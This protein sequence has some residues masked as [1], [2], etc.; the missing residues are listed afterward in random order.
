MERWSHWGPNARSIEVCLANSTGHPLPFQMRGTQGGG[1]EEAV[2][3]EER[4]KKVKRKGCIEVFK[5]FKGRI[6]TRHDSKVF[7]FSVY[8]Q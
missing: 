8:S 4:K 3:G 7:V 1:G 5:Y 2:E 6:R